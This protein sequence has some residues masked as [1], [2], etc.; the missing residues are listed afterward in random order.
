MTTHTIS[1][2][3][4]LLNLEAWKAA[5]SKNLKT[6]FPSLYYRETLNHGHDFKDFEKTP[7]FIKLQ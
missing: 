1:N 7:V 4:E 3:V 5:I 6:K 2:Q